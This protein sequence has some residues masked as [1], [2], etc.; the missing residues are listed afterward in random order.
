[1]R[2]TTYITVLTWR[3]CSANNPTQAVNAIARR[4]PSP[5]FSLPH[6]VSSTPR[7]LSATSISIAEF[8]RWIARFTL[9]KKNAASRPPRYC[10]AKVDTAIGRPNG[11]LVFSSTTSSRPCRPTLRGRAGKTLTTSSSRNGPPS[12]T[13]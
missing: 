4:R 13:A 12:A 11:P 10:S 2:C 7:S 6:A 8:T 9:L 3:G 5:P 1:M